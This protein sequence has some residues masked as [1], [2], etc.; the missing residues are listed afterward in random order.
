[1]IQESVAIK[2]D[3]AQFLGRGIQPKAV[4]F[5]RRSVFGRSSVGP[6]FRLV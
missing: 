3:R 4:S 2:L 5:G 1:M 6:P